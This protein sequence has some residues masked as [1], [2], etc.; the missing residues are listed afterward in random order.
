MVSNIGRFRYI[1]QYHIGF[2]DT[3]YDI[4]PIISAVIGAGIASMVDM[5]N[6]DG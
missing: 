6:I 2:W 4:T 5:A 3:Q 1:S